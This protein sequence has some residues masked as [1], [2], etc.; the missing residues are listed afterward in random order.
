[1]K[2]TTCRFEMSA[3]TV[4]ILS[5]KVSSLSPSRRGEGGGHTWDV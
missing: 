3:L 4:E 2:K 5:F 1:M